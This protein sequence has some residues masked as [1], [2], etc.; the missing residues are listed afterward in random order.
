VA[1][2]SNGVTYY[3]PCATDDGWWY[4]PKHVDQS[5]DK[6]NC[7]TLHLVEYILENS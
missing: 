6:V 2:S 1:G 3:N 7:V 4:N 5:L